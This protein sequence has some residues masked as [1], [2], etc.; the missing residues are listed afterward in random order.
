MRRY[1]VVSTALGLAYF[2]L[3]GLPLLASFPV[4]QPLIEALAGVSLPV[5]IAAAI[6]NLGFFL[7]AYRLLAT[8]LRSDEKAWQVTEG[9]LDAAMLV[10]AMILL[11]LA[12]TFPWIVLR[13]SLGLVQAFSH[14][15]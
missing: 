12:G 8:L 9:R 1:P 3:G 7:G 11:V 2:S 15:H 4:R 10:A 14:L 13:G 5:A 6:G